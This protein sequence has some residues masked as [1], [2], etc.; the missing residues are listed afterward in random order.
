MDLLLQFLPS[1][2]PGQTVHHHPA[3][4]IVSIL[5]GLL[6]NAIML[7][8]LPLPISIHVP[9]AAL[10]VQLA[11][12]TLQKED[13]GASKHWWHNGLLKLQRSI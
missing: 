6:R 4:V 13:S 12:L 1:H 2:R 3:H 11:A 8:H 5:A 7:P 10:M 9:P